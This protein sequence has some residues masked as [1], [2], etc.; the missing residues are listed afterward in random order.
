ME[1][2]RGHLEGRGVVVV[3][4]KVHNVGNQSGVL[5]VALNQFSTVIGLTVCA[6]IDAER[7]FDVGACSSI[8]LSIYLIILIFNIFFF[9]WRF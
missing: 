1:G 7:S 6:V 3:V 5:T 9:F 2:V 8:P 4:L